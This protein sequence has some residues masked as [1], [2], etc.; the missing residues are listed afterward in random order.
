VRDA[1]ARLGSPLVP[2]AAGTRILQLIFSE[3]RADHV[4]GR[5]FVTLKA[6]PQWEPYVEAVLA[7]KM[8]TESASDPVSTSG[9]TTGSNS[10]REQEAV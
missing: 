10:R 7:R 9:R 2:S 3:I 4:D 8:T 1:T 5:L 6:L